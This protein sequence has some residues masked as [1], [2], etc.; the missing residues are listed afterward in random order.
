MKPTVT[1][2]GESIASSKQ[3]DTLGS[4]NP[5]PASEH[6]TNLARLR[7]ATL[8][9]V[10]AVTVGGVLLHPVEAV[11]GELDQ[12]AQR[13]ALL[14]QG[15]IADDQFHPFLYPEL[16]AL[17]SLALDDV[18]ASGRFVSAMAGG[19]LVYYGARIAQLLSSQAGG[20]W[21]FALLAANP[22]IVSH[23]MQVA[24]DMTGSALCIWATWATLCAWN[25]PTAPALAGVAWGLAA[26]ARF[27]FAAFLPSVAIALW[28]QG[29]LTKQ[30]QSGMRWDWWNIG[31]IGLGWTIGY[32]PNLVPT[33]IASGLFHPADNWKN[34][35][36]KLSGN[37]DR[38]F[39]INPPYPDAMHLLTQDG[40]QL[41]SMGYR[42]FEYYWTQGL[43][44]QMLGDV[45]H[46]PAIAAAL[47]LLAAASA[48]FT[49][50]QRRCNQARA[51]TLVCVL[52]T[53]VMCL[54]F[55]QAFRLMIFVLPLSWA[56]IHASLHATLSRR[57]ALIHGLSAAALMLIASNIPTH[58]AEF[59]SL[60][61]TDEI[62][63]AKRLSASVS[64]MTCIASPLSIITQHVPNRIANIE[65]PVKEKLDSKS[66]FRA[67]LETSARN[68]AQYLVCGPLSAM[69]PM[70]HLQ[71]N[72]PEGTK[73][74]EHTP[75]SLV[76]ELSP[77]TSSSWLSNASIEVLEVG[78]VLCRV[79]VTPDLDITSAGI[80]IHMGDGA[81]RIFQL[82]RDT[83]GSFSARIQTADDLKGEFPFVAY[84]ILKDG[85]V[86]QS[87]EFWFR[88]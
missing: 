75:N 83:K 15:I 10:A 28:I 38:E 12:Y 14:L 40:D 52:G 36:L 21:T 16:V 50:V 20:W 25:K 8:A 3:N 63:A 70:E 51:S 65:V 81:P 80:A 48:L 66:F 72:L 27:N 57:P 62:S 77:T 19:I 41:L 85:T 1:Q 18:F 78:Q 42:D 30:S 67:A 2:F 11:G 55:H 43:G 35:S 82:T 61:P 47:S 56:A 64:P 31:A 23:S 39:L 68:G 32:A 49:L 9:W 4:R 7:I 34:L 5:R 79:D 33:Y 84:A 59:A 58:F 69:L 37:W 54:T 74:L 86:S 53:V 45:A 88:K 6:R 29:K 13:A 44:L 24:S 46:Q 22:A 73:V 60:H 87:R 26:A 17:C 76:L 71:M